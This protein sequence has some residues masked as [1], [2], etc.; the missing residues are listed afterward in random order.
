MANVL[1]TGGTGLIGA[2]VTRQLLA[3]GHKPVAFD[4]S[5]SYENI[6][7]VAGDVAVVRGDV[8]D[9]V[10]LLHAAREHHID[11]II[12]LA[13]FI[14]HESNANPMRSAQV[15]VMGSGNIFDLALALDIER[16]GFASTNA[17]YG[18]P[19]LYNNRPA[20]EADAPA[21]ANPYG[22]AKRLV[23][24]IAETYVSNFGLGLVGLR[25]PLSYG[26]G[27]LTGGTGG[28]NRMVRNAAL[29]QSA[30]LDNYGS[31]QRLIQPIHVR[32][33]ARAFIVATL[34][35]RL[36]R[37]LYNAPVDDPITVQQA[38]DTVC[39]VVPGA[40]VTILDKSVP[41]AWSSPTIDGSLFKRDAGFKPEV[42]LS[43]GISQMVGHYRAREAAHVGDAPVA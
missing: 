11:H 35:K 15:N 9:I 43:E 40:D 28:F 25:P 30:V 18:A 29:G 26:V 23:E 12:H 16:V 10:G 4:F 6:A 2:E 8:A 37:H 39:E 31:P 36:P 34:G 42:S 3:A 32:D 1:V 22:A 21:P 38:V 5:P 41:G 14:L 33:M 13:A 27:R 24:I 17:V 19:A 7:D 20:T